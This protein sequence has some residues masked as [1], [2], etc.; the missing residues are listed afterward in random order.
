MQPSL[1]RCPETTKQSDFTVEAKL[2]GKVNHV[3]ENII[4]E[5][6]VFATKR[7]TG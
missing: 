2:L 3:Q 5:I 1:A 7:P 4:D 6:E